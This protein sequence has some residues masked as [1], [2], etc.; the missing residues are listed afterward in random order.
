MSS[1]AAPF[2]LGAFAAAALAA[3][4]SASPT[5]QAATAAHPHAADVWA[6]R[7][8]A[9]HVPVEPGTR[10]RPIVED[11]M[12]RH[13]ERVQLTQDEWRELIEFLAFPAKDAG[14]DASEK[15]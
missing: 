1:P 13:H 6:N 2:A 4:V 12:S 3:C 7:C 8:G 15:K 5:L 9:C 10:P 11:A 14:K